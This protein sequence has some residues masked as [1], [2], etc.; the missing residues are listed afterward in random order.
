MDWHFVRSRR[1]ITHDIVKLI[2]AL[3]LEVPYPK[4]TLSGNRFWENLNLFIVEREKDLLWKCYK[5]IIEWNTS[6]CI[7]WKWVTMSYLE[8]VIKSSKIE[9]GSL[10]Y[11]RIIIQACKRKGKGQQRSVKAI[12]KK[13]LQTITLKAIVSSKLISIYCMLLHSKY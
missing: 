9:K 6:H 10:T 12:K 1:Q 13:W 3:V 8:F 11:C 2:I 5:R 4:E 7:S